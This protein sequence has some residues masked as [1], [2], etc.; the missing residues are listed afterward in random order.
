LGPSV[1]ETGQQLVMHSAP[2]ECFDMASVLE[3]SGLL[4]CYTEWQV[5]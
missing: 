1:Y 5:Y 2:S 3:D 4:G